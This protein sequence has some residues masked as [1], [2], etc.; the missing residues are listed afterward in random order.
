VRT[1]GPYMLVF[2]TAPGTAKAV[3]AALKA[4]EWPEVRGT[5]A[6]ESMLFLATDNVFDTRLLMQ[7]L[8]RIIEGS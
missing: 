5:V 2:D 1:A 3:G 8:K 6:D 4:T 7:R